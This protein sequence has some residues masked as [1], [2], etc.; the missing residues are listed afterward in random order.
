MATGRAP[1]PRN[2]FGA[3]QGGARDSPIR[4]PNQ[5]GT[6]RPRWAGRLGRGGE[7]AWRGQRQLRSGRS[8]L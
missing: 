4:A 2:S 1:G 7:L 6:G 3:R 8:S 5:P